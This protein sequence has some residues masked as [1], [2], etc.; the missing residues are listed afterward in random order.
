VTLVPPTQQGISRNARSDY[1]YVLVRDL[2]LAADRLKPVHTHTQGQD[3]YIQVDLPPIRY[4]KLRLRSLLPV[5][6]QLLYEYMNVNATL[7][8]SSCMSKSAL[9]IGYMNCVGAQ[10]LVPLHWE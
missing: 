3:S 2:Q 1:E 4:L 9:L 8:F 5:I 7:V 6:E 10:C